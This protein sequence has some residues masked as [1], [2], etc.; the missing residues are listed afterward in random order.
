[1]YNTHAY[2]TCFHLGSDYMGHVT[3]DDNISYSGHHRQQSVACVY[4]D[5]MAYITALWHVYIS[6]P[7]V[8]STFFAPS[9]TKPV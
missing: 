7:F 8:L 5:H 3:L 6:D 1:M 4:T 2:S 9:L